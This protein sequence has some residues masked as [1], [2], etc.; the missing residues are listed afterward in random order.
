MIHIKRIVVVLARQ[1]VLIET[2]DRGSLGDWK[3]RDGYRV[4]YLALICSLASLLTMS[5]STSLNTFAEIHHSWASRVI[6]P[7]SALGLDVHIGS[8]K[9]GLAV[10]MLVVDYTFDFALVGYTKEPNTDLVGK[11]AASLS[12]YAFTTGSGFLGEL[13]PVDEGSELMAVIHGCGSLSADTKAN[14]FCRGRNLKYTPKETVFG[15]FAK[16]AWIYSA[17]G[18][19]SLLAGNQLNL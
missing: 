17:N 5:E 2:S 3:D 9:V 7:T 6:V 18:T 12:R 11:E 15:A 4:C 8:E 13:K 1:R 19:A 16:G 10:V 14:Q